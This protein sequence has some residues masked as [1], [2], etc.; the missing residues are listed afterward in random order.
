MNMNY[1]NIYTVLASTPVHENVVY[2]K[3]KLQLCCLL[4]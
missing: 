2:Y 4:L 3:H 1:N